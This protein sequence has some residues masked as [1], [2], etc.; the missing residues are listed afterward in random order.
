MIIYE[1]IIG[2]ILMKLVNLEI[3]HN[4][5]MSQQFPVATFNFSY[6][7]TE[8]SCIFDTTTEPYSIIFFKNI[9]GT[10]LSINVYKGYIV[11]DFIGDKKQF[12]DFWNYFNLEKKNGTFSLS[13]FYSYL[14]S[15][16]PNF[17]DRREHHNRAT[18]AIVKDVE[19]MDKIYFKGFINW[20]KVRAES[21]NE[22]KGRTRRNLEKTKL[23]YPE[24][25]EA[26]KDL[27]ISVRY[28][29]KNT[30]NAENYKNLLDL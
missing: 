8:F 12:W 25:Y 5:M 13:D 18:I 4:E 17:F 24:I 2:G 20:E 6:K 7:N 27:D 3:L 30:Q 1:T 11:D 10:K 21:G 19:E 9:S 29:T 26:I 15:Q 16:I 22:T 28:S 14:N 23:L